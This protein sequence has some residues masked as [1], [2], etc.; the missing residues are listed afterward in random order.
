[1]NSAAR[2]L[3]FAGPLYV[4]LVTWP[5]WWLSGLEAWA[6]PALALYL[7]ARCLDRRALTVNIPIIGLFLMLLW[8]GLSFISAPDDTR[9][10]EECLAVA[11]QLVFMLAAWNS[12]REQME[13]DIDRVLRGLRICG[14][15]YIAGAV[16]ALPP[17]F[18]GHMPTALGPIATSDTGESMGIF[19]GSA[20]V[21]LVEGDS[22]A[23]VSLSSSSTGLLLAAVIFLVAWVQ[24]LT[25]AKRKLP[26]T[27]G[28]LATLGLIVAASIGAW[29]A[30][31][32]LTE[33]H[34]G[35]L[36]RAWSHW[37]TQLLIGLSMGG[38]EP[39]GPAG[40]GTA[41]SDVAIGH[42]LIG[43]VFA[44]LLWAGALLPAVRLARS[45]TV[46]QIIDGRLLVAG[47]SGVLLPVF[48]LR[49]WF[50][51]G[52]Q[53]MVWSIFLVAILSAR[54]A[55]IPPLGGWQED[56][57][58]F[59]LRLR[60]RL[61]ARR[62]DLFT[63][64]TAWAVMA[65][66]ILI[67]AALRFYRLGYQSLW[68]DE[69]VSWRLS[70]GTIR[71]IIW[72]SATWENHPPGIYALFHVAIKLLG[73]AE[74]VVRL[75][76]AI[77]GV[78]S[79]PM[80]YLLGKRAYDQETG[81]LAAGLLIF[82]YGAVYYSQ[83]AR[84][85]GM[86]AFMSILSFYLWLEI[87]RD[88]QA[89]KKTGLA[90]LFSYVVVSVAGFQLNYHYAM[91]VFVQATLLLRALLQDRSLTRLFLIRILPLYVAFLLG[92]NYWL[93]VIFRKLAAPRLDSLSWLTVP[94]WQDARLFQQLFFGDS[95][96]L[97]L[98]E[99]LLLTLL[100]MSGVARL[101]LA[102]SGRPTGGNRSVDG[103]MWLWLVGPAAILL[104]YSLLFKPAYHPRYLMVS[105]PASMLLLARAAIVLPLSSHR[106]NLGGGASLV[107]LSAALLLEGGY[108]TSPQ[109]TQYREAVRYFLGHRSQEEPIAG[110]YFDESEIDY[111]LLRAGSPV[112]ASLKVGEDGDEGRLCDW[113]VTDGI[114]R[115]WYLEGKKIPA[116]G[117]DTFL[118]RS[119]GLLDEARYYKS[120]VRLLDVRADSCPPK[121]KEQTP[122]AAPASLEMSDAPGIPGAARPH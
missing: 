55:R 66:F 56:L 74:W 51:A 26:A 33:E 5:L 36:A 72:A 91:I 76:P 88:F 121:T 111:Y 86:I 68:L 78:L 49:V 4:L 12:P 30:D 50:D 32:P 112:R 85:Y 13:T 37:Q 39:P 20:S 95:T 1:V 92:L 97:L 108:Y 28:A 69:L 22:G 25:R 70:S 116:D 34:L 84:A 52:S 87:Y 10:F 21:S 24:Y 82:S 96:L 47:F 59:A 48:G 46:S 83:E 31:L 106:I 98:A 58:G 119:F 117:F 115:F 54:V 80:I 99:L 40:L 61:G 60:N 113:I 73:D 11:S 15:Y 7:A 8:W 100:A 29:Q 38:T 17:G 109:K 19:Q 114:S 103:V 9:N 62:D 27:L 89:G 93:V 42:G 23:L 3:S 102:R 35:G 104:S 90:H 79:V 77:T 45:K 44:G 57:P 110:S 6:P 81:L 65:G 75:F 118:Q 2:C 53:L 18:R 101:G 14:L 122:I 16:I 67:A 107:V 120:R 105:L 94:T 41:L 71:S 63:P 64:R 43:L